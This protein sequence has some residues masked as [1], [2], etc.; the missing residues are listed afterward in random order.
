MAYELFME[1]FRELGKKE[2]RSATVFENNPYGL[3]VDE[4]G[5][6]EAYCDDEDCDCR[7]VFLNFVSRKRDEIIAVVTYGWE[8]KAFYRK[9][10]GGSDSE[11]AREA[12]RE[13]TGLGLNSASRQSKFAPAALRLVKDLLQ[14]PNYVARIKRHYK[15]FKETV[16][17]QPVQ[18][19]APFEMPTIPKLSSIPIDQAAPE[20]VV[21]K[22]RNRHHSRRVDR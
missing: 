15:Q 13:M 6:L 2:T 4:Y 12:V 1:R 5:L 22:S 7:R 19:A 21:S 9:W 17:N 18:L 8:D 10:F 3:P 14:D 20:K 11:A 16:D